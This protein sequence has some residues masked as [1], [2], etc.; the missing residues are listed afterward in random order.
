MWQE[1]FLKTNYYLIWKA[2][3][4]YHKALHL[5]CYS[6]PR[7]ASDIVS[8]ANSQKQLDILDNCLLFKEH[9]RMILNKINKAIGLLHKLHNILPRSALLTI[10]RT[11]SGLILTTAKLFTTKLIM[12]LFIRNFNWYNVMLACSNRS[13]KRYFKRR[14]L[15]KTSFG[16]PSVPSLVQKTFSFL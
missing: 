16:L 7:S 9:L 1:K 8:E 6:S 2:V 10:Y 11:L 14:I 4:Y 5:G 12:Q 3:N 13:S 15:R